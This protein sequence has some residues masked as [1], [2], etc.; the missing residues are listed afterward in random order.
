MEQS[1]SKVKQTLRVYWPF[2]VFF[3]VLA[4]M[5]IFMPLIRDDAVY[6]SKILE[7]ANSLGAIIS[8]LAEHAAMKYHVTGARVILDYTFAP[9]FSHFFWLYKIINP[10][11]FTAIGVL[12]SKIFWKDDSTRTVANIC[13]AL[14]LIIF[15]FS[16]LYGAGWVCCSVN[17]LWAVFFALIVIYGI[18]KRLIEEKKISGI[19]YVGYTISLIIAV[20]M[21][22]VCVS[23]LIFLTAVRIYASR[24]KKPYAFVSI[25]WLI[26]LAALLFDLTCP[27][28]K[29]RIADE[30]SA[31]FPG[32]LNLSIFGKIHL[33]LYG[34]MQSITWHSLLFLI[35]TM[36]IACL[37][38]QKKTKPLFRVISVLPPCYFL[39]VAGLQQ[40]N[41]SAYNN[42][43]NGMYYWD[44]LIPQHFWLPYA[45]D[46]CVVFICVCIIIS[47]YAIFEDIPKTAIMT[48]ILG[49]GFATKAMLGAS[50]SVFMSGERT[51]VFFHFCVIIVMIFLLQT[52]D[53]KR[54]DTKGR[55]IVL[56]SFPAI[57]ELAVL[58]G[59][60]FFLR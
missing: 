58:A 39:A 43:T 36:F 45:V 9:F 40:L 51:M 52:L 10:V 29:E 27:G 57:Y 46:L 18:K 24:E 42:L 23:M 53:L 59:T 35:F 30:T 17:Y 19:G 12:L 60:V 48:G 21:E 1:Q 16:D 7:G 50:A 20:N 3:L 56:F 22:Q 2:L 26:N 25:L 14:F 49:I 8:R 6:H 33:G 32:F 13:I 37:V 15:P 34:L 38:W 11:I 28:V 54:E 4:F 47:I 41:L 5:H 44:T 55:V 31:Y